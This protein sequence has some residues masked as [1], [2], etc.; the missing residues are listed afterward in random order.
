[1]KLNDFVY[2]Q[3]T[4]PTDIETST[5]DTKNSLEHQMISNKQITV[6][7]LI[8]F[9][10]SRIVLESL[11]TEIPIVVAS[12]Y[13][14]GQSLQTV[15]LFYFLTIVPSKLLLTQSSLHH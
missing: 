3:A 12:H 8:V 1:M 14:Y 10:F 11:F 7:F 15:S 9:T 13:W 6:F 4:V 5:S 2:A